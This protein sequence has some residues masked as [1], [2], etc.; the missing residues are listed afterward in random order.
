MIE[1]ELLYVAGIAG[2]SLG[3]YFFGQSSLMKHTPDRAQAKVFIGAAIYAAGI[4]LLLWGTPN[5]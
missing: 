3:G 2:L 5:L 1:P 4:A